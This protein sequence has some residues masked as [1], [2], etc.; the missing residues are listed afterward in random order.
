MCTEDLTGT[1]WPAN[2]QHKWKGAAHVD[3][4]CKGVA[5]HL[6]IHWSIAQ[7]LSHALTQRRAVFDHS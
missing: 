7:Q 4:H 1:D 6:L 3:T 5:I 2:D